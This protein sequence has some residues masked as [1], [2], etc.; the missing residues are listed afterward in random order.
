MRNFQVIII[1]YCCQN[2]GDVVDLLT[3]PP[4][5]IYALKNVRSTLEGGL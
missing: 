1:A 4:G 3:W 5:E 2:N